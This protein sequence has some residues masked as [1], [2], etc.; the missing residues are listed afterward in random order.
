MAHSEHKITRK[1]PMSANKLYGNYTISLP[2]RWQR[3][4]TL[5]CGCKNVRTSHG[6]AVITEFVP[7]KGCSKHKFELVD[8]ARWGVPESIGLRPTQAEWSVLRELV[9]QRDNFVCQYCFASGVELECDH[10]I[11]VSRGG[12]S[13]IAN[14]TTACQPCNRAKSDKL[15]SEWEERDV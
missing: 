5:K 4:R 12:S 2:V 14:L 7:A 9:F 3:S 11:P 8:P 6:F 15:L 13:D 1:R 10:I